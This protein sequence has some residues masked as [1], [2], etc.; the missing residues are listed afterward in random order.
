MHTFLYNQ[1]FTSCTLMR[2][3]FTSC[4]CVHRGYNRNRKRKSKRA[5]CLATAANVHWYRAKQ[6]AERHST[7]VY[8]LTTSALSRS[9]A[10]AQCSFVKAHSHSHSYSVVQ[11]YQPALLPVSQYLDTLLCVC[12]VHTTCVQTVLLRS[13]CTQQCKQACI[14]STN[15][16]V[17][18]ANTEL[19][20]QVLA[21]KHIALIDDVSFQVSC[22]SLS[23]LGLPLRTVLSYT[24]LLVS[25]VTNYSWSF[26]QL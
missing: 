26:A 15:N 5:K 19:I 13:Q 1:W 18:S 25:P 10:C 7:L 3:C 20:V 2:V 14:N 21:A 6:C 8:S 23:P 22:S 12:F 11:L 16:S 24:K 17:A 9:S 4:S